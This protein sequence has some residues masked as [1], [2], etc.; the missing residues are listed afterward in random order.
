M[1]G[2]DVREIEALD[3]VAARALPAIETQDVAGWIVRCSPGLAVRRA[4]SVWPRRHGDAQELDEK[5]AAVE[6]FYADRGLPARYQVSPASQP[7]GLELALRQRG[8]MPGAPTAVARCDLASIAG[9][10]IGPRSMVKIAEFASDSWWA[11]WQTALRINAAPLDAVA[12]LVDRISAPTAFVSVAL[13]GVDAAVALGV[14]E[15]RWLGIFNMATL[16]QMRRRA[17]GRAALVAL[18]AW[19]V[20][21]DATKGYLQVDLDNSPALNLYPVHRLQARLP[22]RVPHPRAGITLKATTPPPSSTRPRTH[23][24]TADEHRM[25]KAG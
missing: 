17:A 4:N 12:G 19:A 20:E 8:Y 16:P 24:P 15:D 21:R 10:A 2:A 5:L 11:T 25:S 1:S 9:Q 13:E 3:E 14:L 18:A 7:H 22:I 23:Q 6:R